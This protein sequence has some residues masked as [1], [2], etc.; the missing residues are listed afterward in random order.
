MLP[1]RFRAEALE[2]LLAEKNDDEVVTR[3]AAECGGTVHALTLTILPAWPHQL[4]APR[5]GRRSGSNTLLRLDQTS[6]PWWSPL[7][8]TNPTIG[9]EARWWKG[10]K[11]SARSYVSPMFRRDC[12][13]HRL[14][15][16]IRDGAKLADEAT[17]VCWANID[18]RNV[19]LAWD[20]G[21]GQQREAVELEGPAIIDVRESAGS[22][23]DVRPVRLETV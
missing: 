22:A 23:T 2:V 4:A 5:I 9:M 21:I 6:I 11:V 14:E 19:V 17:W 18:S 10:G 8:R 15:R 20:L 7:Q 1:Q 12:S 16:R 13:R 3:V